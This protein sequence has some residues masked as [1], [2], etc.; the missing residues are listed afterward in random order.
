MQSHFT[1]SARNCLRRGVRYQGIHTGTYAGKGRAGIY[2]LAVSGG[3]LGAAFLLPPVH[4]DIL[5]AGDAPGTGTATIK[6]PKVSTGKDELDVIT[7]GANNYHTVSTDASYN[8]KQPTPFSSISGNG[9]A[10]RDLAFH[11]KHAA[12]VDAAGNIYQWG[13][14]FFDL[15]GDNQGQKPVLTLSGKDITSI[16][17][18]GSKVYALS[19]TGKVYVL[20]SSQKK[21]AVTEETPGMHSSWWSLSW[22][23]KTKPTVDFIE[24]HMEAKKQQNEKFISISAGRSHLLAL[25]SQGRTFTAPITAS[26]NSHGQLGMRKVQLCLPPSP[27]KPSQPTHQT[28]ELLPKAL[29]DPY[30]R[31]APAI[32]AASI[33]P[34][35]PPAATV[36]LGDKTFDETDIRYCD[37]LFEIPSLKGIVAA[38][39]VAGDRSSYVRTA[40]EGRI[41]GFGANEFGQMVLGGSYST[42]F[43]PAPTEIVL[44]RGYPGGTNIKCI[45][46]AAG[47]DIVYFTVE[48]FRGTLPTPSDVN[49]DLLAAGMGQFGSLGNAGYVQA[50]GSPVKVKAISGVK[51]YNE[52]TQSNQPLAPKL[53][54]ASP[55]GHTIALLDTFDLDGNT[56]HQSHNQARKGRD[57]FV[58][59]ANANYQLG[60]GKRSSIAVPTPLPSDAFIGGY[61]VDQ[62][63]GRMMARERTAQVLMDLQGKKVAKNAKVEQSVVAGWGCSAIYWKIV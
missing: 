63:L 50:Q 19:R 23:W 33:T 8:P 55:T 9:V 57:I 45:D 51:E 4:Q 21:Q 29:V 54:S 48:T 53:V 62:H 39:A 7:W 14:G 16:A 26:A 61:D 42:E 60:L 56:H 11:E 34:S 43:V 44:S 25:T 31:S 52:L 27:S 12:C 24:L 2:I 37:L 6:L 20:S 47:G 41:L 22:L 3:L 18:S 58:W 17:L 10:L 32:R 28:V 46:V 40:K 35:A 15:P 59:G 49:I 30:A 5:E 1:H 13:D 36:H 38:Q